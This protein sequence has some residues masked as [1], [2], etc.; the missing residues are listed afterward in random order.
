MFKKIEQDVGEEKVYSVFGTPSQHTYGVSK[1]NENLTNGIKITLTSSGY[2][3]Q[4]DPNTLEFSPHLATLPFPLL[5]NK[6]FNLSLSH[7]LCFSR[8]TVPHQSPLTSSSI[9]PLSTP[10]L[11]RH[12]LISLVIIS[13]DKIDLCLVGKHHLSLFLSH[14]RSTPITSSS[15]F[16][17][18]TPN[19]DSRYLA[20][21]IIIGLIGNARNRL[22]I[23]SNHNAESFLAAF[24]SDFARRFLLT[25]FHFIF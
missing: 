9:F 25:L 19:L 17:L 2:I 4:K 23:V 22:F 8:S 15:I 18:S 11:D 1:T 3:K 24:N 20:S 16:P 5:Q 21:P 6:K 10:N 13:S 14:Y 7:S 12:C